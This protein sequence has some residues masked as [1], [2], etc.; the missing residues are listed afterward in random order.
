MTREIVVLGSAS[1]VPTRQRNHNG[2]LAV[3]DEE[4]TLVDPGEGTQRQLLFA[5]VAVSAVSRICITHFH[6]DHCLGLPGVLQ[7]MSLDKVRGPVPVAYPAAGAPYFER[8]RHA[9]AYEDTTEIVPV[10]VDAPDGTPVTVLRA[11]RPAVDVQAAALTHRVPTIGWRIQER[12]GRTMLPDHLASAGVAGPDIARL[13][14]D[15][16][17]RAGGRTVTLEEVS[18][19][20]RPQ[21]VAFVMDTRWC[22]GALALA[23]GV[24]LLVCEATFDSAEAELAERAGHLTAAQ[25][26]R[27]AREAGARRLVVTHFSQRYPDVSALVDQAALAYGGDVVAATDL[28]R[29]ALPP[30]RRPVAP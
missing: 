16:A 21:S 23:D 28:L 10:P 7:R 25:A 19:D 12:A 4:V 9:S 6:G 20:R 29:V 1:Q 14:R 15:G 18:V 3:F 24:D 8:L 27:L 17:V 30:R 13:R 2:Y 22:D 26:G 11:T 5:G